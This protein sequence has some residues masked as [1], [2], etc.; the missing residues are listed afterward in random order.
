MYL[1]ERATQVLR[2]TS[3][4]VVALNL[5]ALTVALAAGITRNNTRTIQLSLAELSILTE[6]KG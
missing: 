5:G 4:Q 6:G 1:I 2:K 3:E